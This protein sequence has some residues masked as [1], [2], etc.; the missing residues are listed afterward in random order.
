MAETYLITG[1]GGFL[2][3]ELIH[4]LLGTPRKQ[5]LALTSRPQAIMDKFPAPAP[6]QVYTPSDWKNHRIPLHKVDRLIHAGFARSRD[7]QKL[8]DS[9]EFTTKLLHQATQH[10]TKAFINISTE[11]VYGNTQGP[12][13]EDHK[14]SPADAYGLAKLASEQ[15]VKVVA[16]QSAMPVVN[17]RL[18]SLVGQSMDIFK[19]NH[20]VSILS[21]FITHA[22]QGLP[23]LIQG[24]SQTYSLMDVS[25]AAAAILALA[26]LPSTQWQQVYNVGTDIRLNILQLAELVQSIA[27]QY[28]CPPVTIKILPGPA[29]DYKVMDSSRLY[30]DT[31]WKPSMAASEIIHALF[32]HPAFR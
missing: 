2:G 23:I 27:P 15:L 30:Q 28:N 25:D 6:L 14:S 17:L 11:G 19:K 7:P 16:R 8:G 1:A 24:G 31:Q 18:S 5:I 29:A 26:N 4:Q 3:T 32:K 13:T 10:G 20:A 22:K 9:L 12:W 21:R